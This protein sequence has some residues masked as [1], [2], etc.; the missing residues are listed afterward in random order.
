M[1]FLFVLFLIV[2]IPLFTLSFIGRKFSNPYKLYFLLGKK[3]SGKST[4]MVKEML[5]AQRRGYW[6]YTDIKDCIVPD[7]RIIDAA[8]LETFTPVHDSALFLDEVGITFD[9]RHFKAFSDGHRD[10]FKFQRKYKVICWQNSQGYDIDLKIKVLID[11]IYLQSVL[12]NVIGISRP[13]SKSWTLTDPT[14]DSESRPAERMKFEPI[15]R[16]EF[17]WLPKYFKYFD[18]F[19]APPRYPIPYREVTLEQFETVQQQRKLKALSS[20]P[21]DDV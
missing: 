9:N 16:W 13:V 8:D 18:S 6:I 2:F 7:V 11:R 17:T 1:K 19:D 21:K 14:G 4:K 12:F 20:D 3:G 5:K 15:W 10:W